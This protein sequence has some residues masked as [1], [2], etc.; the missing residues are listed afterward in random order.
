[1]RYVIMANGRGSRWGN[2]GGVPK[3]LVE[4]AG[5]TLLQRLV[6]QL[7]EIDPSGDIVISSSNPAYETPGARRHEPL[8]NS[9]ELD[10]FV[11][12]LLVNQT[13]FLYGDTYYSD[14]ALRS[15]L[16]SSVED[17]GFFGDERAI[18]AVGVTDVELMLQHL[19]RVRSL[20][21]SGEI[22]SCVGWQL[23]QSYAGLPFG[24]G[25]PG[26]DFHWV[27]E[28]TAGFNTPEQFE[29]FRNHFPQN[30]HFVGDTG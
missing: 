28:L 9:I 2:Y 27:S 30:D 5:E 19:R 3:H 13:W 14:E 1:M 26:D 25:S 12:E 21:L 20:F 15:I 16:S 24:K 10:R 23:Y 29:V 7:S 6:R 18:V 22:S 11:P 17:I 8:E 4:V